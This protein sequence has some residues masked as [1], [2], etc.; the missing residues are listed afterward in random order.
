[1]GV[2]PLHAVVARP[3]VGLSTAA[4]YSRCTPSAAGRGQA[5][6]LADALVAGR[7]R[8]ALDLLHNDLEP[9][10]RDM[11]AEVDRL[12]AL[13][14][15]LGAVRPL[16]T[17]SG[18]ACFTLARSAAEARRLAARLALEGCPWA[19]PVRLAPLDRSVRARAAG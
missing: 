18:S 13:L 10:A 1:M 3:A 17:G 12:L 19:V 16:L 7:F 8:A 4:V 15:R 11:C 6:R 14:E 9:P 2:P 5:R